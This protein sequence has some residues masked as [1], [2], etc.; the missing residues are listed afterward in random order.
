MRA[1]EPPPESDDEGTGAERSSPPGPRRHLAVRAR[2]GRLPSSDE[3]R[4]EA[5]DA[6]AEARRRR[7]HDWTVTLTYNDGSTAHHRFSG[8]DDGHDPEEIDELADGDPQQ[9]SA[10]APAEQSAS[11]RTMDMF[12]EHVDAM[13]EFGED[14][15][16][17]DDEEQ[18]DDDH[19]SEDEEHDQDTDAMP[20]LVSHDDDDDE[21]H[22]AAGGARGPGIFG[23]VPDG[24]FDGD[25]VNPFPDFGLLAG[26]DFDDDGDELPPIPDFDLHDAAQMQ[27][28]A[29]ADRE[30]W[31]FDFLP[32]SGTFVLDE[33]ST[34]DC[35]EVFQTPIRHSLPCIIRGSEEAHRWNGVLLDEERVI[36]IIADPMTGHVE[37]I[38]I[39]HFG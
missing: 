16:A 3:G 4:S 38:E 25:T 5:A 37:E 36:G 12:L 39:H 19:L 18:F 6:D 24:D 35:P 30:D 33:A 22:A 34:L 32:T 29:S 7:D 13:E 15:L 11:D 10:D 14:D 2:R 8:R 17:L 1:E 28:E 9:G 21:A 23:L 26:G 31:T 20:M 27:I